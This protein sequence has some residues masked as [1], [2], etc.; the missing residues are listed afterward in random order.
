MKLTLA[1]FVVALT[2]EIT[3][4]AQNPDSSLDSPTIL[5]DTQNY[6][7]GRYLAAATTRVRQTWFSVMPEIA[8]KGEKGRVVVVFTIVRNGKVEDTRL[9]VSSGKEALNRAA[10]LAIEASSPF[11]A[12][13]ADFKGDRIVL[14]LPFLY[15]MRTGER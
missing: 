12:L 14:Q 7:F 11:A 4:F 8:L 9:I 5:S 10:E 1:A 3:A 15:N 13:P 6:D 2:L